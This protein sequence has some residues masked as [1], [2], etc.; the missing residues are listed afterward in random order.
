MYIAQCSIL[1]KL[2][3]VCAGV[4]FVH[5][6]YA[7]IIYSAY[8]P[9]APVA[10]VKSIVA[11]QINPADKEKLNMVN[12]LKDRGFL[13]V[14]GQNSLYMQQSSGLNSKFASKYKS[15]GGGPTC[16]APR[17][18]NYVAN[19]RDADDN[20]YPWH[21]QIM[22]FNHE[23]GAS[24]TFCGGTLISPYHVLT[25]AHCYDEMTKGLAESTHVIFRGLGMGTFEAR[26]YKVILHEEYVPAMSQDDADDIGKKPGPTNDLCILVLRPLPEHIRKRLIP[27]CLPSE[28]AEIDEGTVCKVMGHGF[29]SHL[30]E[31]TFTMP[32][33]LQVADVRISSNEDCKADVESPTI[34]DKI[35]ENTICV[36]GP[37]QP[38]VGDSGGPLICSGSEPNKIEGAQEDHQSD[39]FVLSSHYKPRRYYLVGVTSFAVS[40]DENDSC[41]EFKS[42]VFGLTTKHHDWIKE[43]ISDKSHY[44]LVPQP[45]FMMPPQYMQ[46]YGNRMY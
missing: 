13:S 32:S 29:T 12:I 15:H 27:V 44:Q 45:Q 35:N 2:L 46:Q 8:P 42:A 37:I 38:C 16:G 36:R 30:D 4:S 28:Q 20:D 34:K 10:P 33:K 26:V 21:V 7:N 11:A 41:G 9:V 43:I 14:L 23:N 24:E 6:Q 5:A 31:K 18:T 1:L 3:L 39:E 19:G 22:I 17:I 25:A 40:T